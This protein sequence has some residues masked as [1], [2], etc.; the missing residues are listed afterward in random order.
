MG[1]LKKLSWPQKLLIVAASDLVEEGSS[2]L[3]ETLRQS[4]RRQS[5]AGLMKGAIFERNSI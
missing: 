4:C 2:L 1:R 3:L 5:P